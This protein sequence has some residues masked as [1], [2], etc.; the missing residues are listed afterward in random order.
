MNINITQDEFESLKSRDSIHLECQFC[1]KVFTLKK[2]E[3]QQIIAGKGA[4]LFCSRKCASLS[5]RTREVVNCTQC[6]A[7][8]E[9]IPSEIGINNFCSRSCSAKY[10]NAHKKHGARRSKLEIYIEEQI[11]QWQPNLIMICNDCSLIQSELD[12]YFPELKLA[13]ELNGIFHYEPIY[14]SDKFERIQFNDAQKIIRCHEA[15]VELCVID[16]SSVKNLTASAKEKYW[17]LIRGLL[18]SVL[19]RKE[20]NGIEP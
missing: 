18:C 1:D 6:G 7:M 14:G 4:G 17:N 3:V 19:A 10:N 16:T 8:V 13:I 20:S 5:S 2:H 15:G 11:I 9:K 12:F